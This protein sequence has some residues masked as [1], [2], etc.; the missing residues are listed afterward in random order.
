MK[1]VK[2][3]F[4]SA[5]VL[6]ALSSFFTQS[7]PQVLITSIPK[8]GTNLLCYCIGLITEQKKSEWCKGYSLLNEQQILNSR[9]FT[10][11]SHAFYSTRNNAQVSNMPWKALFIYRDPRDQI[12]SMA[13]W[14]YKNPGARPTYARMDMDSLLLELIKRNGPIYSILFDGEEIKNA[15]SIADFYAL[16]MPWKQQPRVY[17]T[18]FEALVG[19]LGGGDAEKQLTEIMNIAAHIGTPISRKQ[20]RSV[21]NR[22]FGNSFTFHEGQIG[23]WKKY[24][25]EEHKKAFKKVAGQLL[26]DLSYEHDFSW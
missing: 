12:I 6:V 21:A 10:F 18:T 19:P 9:A 26:I 17:T 15:R 1:V 14:I 7:Q 8:C 2:T 23:S 16:Y 25:K 4:F 3:I 11:I 20:A 13:N 22:L 24:F 5:S